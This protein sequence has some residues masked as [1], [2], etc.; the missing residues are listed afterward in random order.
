MFMTSITLLR[1]V[2]YDFMC[3]NL[4]ETCDLLMQILVSKIQ[5]QYIPHVDFLFQDLY[6]SISSINRVE[7]HLSFMS[8]THI[9]REGKTRVADTTGNRRTAGLFR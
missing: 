2:L 5:L 9:Y 1:N 4:S 8:L 6:I 7:F 3:Y